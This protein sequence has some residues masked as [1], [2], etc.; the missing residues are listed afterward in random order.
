[1]PDN[2][3]EMVYRGAP[4]E[5]KIS[6]NIDSAMSEGEEGPC[7]MIKPCVPKS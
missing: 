1:M 6:L 7:V 4:I 2:K 5:H 3:V